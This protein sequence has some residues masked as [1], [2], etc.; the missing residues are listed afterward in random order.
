MCNNRRASFSTKNSEK[1]QDLLLKRRTYSNCI[2]TD[3]NIYITL[4]SILRRETTQTQ[5]KR[6]L[7]LQTKKSLYK[8]L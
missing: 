2:K 7:T 1:I 3:D 5:L 8:K 6:L 4:N